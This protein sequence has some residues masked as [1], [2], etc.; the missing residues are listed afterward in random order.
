MM[1][2]NNGSNK[3]VIARIARNTCNA[4]L[5]ELISWELMDFFYRYRLYL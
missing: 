2:A 1:R 5:N 3:L 4:I